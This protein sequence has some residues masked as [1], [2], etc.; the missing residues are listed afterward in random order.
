[1]AS[2]SEITV[3]RAKIAELLSDPFNPV[4]NKTSLAR[5]FDVDVRTIYRDIESAE[6][7]DRIREIINAHMRSDAISAAFKVAL[8]AIL[9]D[10]KFTA[11]E[12]LNTSIWLLEISKVFETDQGESSEHKSVDILNL[13]FCADAK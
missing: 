6:C 1:M 2:D 8:S 4:P 12:Q 9:G 10:K 3:R 11:K 13:I 7:R 5:M